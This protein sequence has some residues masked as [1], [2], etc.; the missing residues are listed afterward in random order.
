MKKLADFSKTHTCTDIRTKVDVQEGCVGPLHQDLLRRTMK[1]LIHEVHAV[2]H[3][4][5]DLLRVVLK[6]TQETSL[7]QFL[8]AILFGV[9]TFSLASSPSTSISR[10]GYMDTYCLANTLY[11]EPATQISEVSS[12]S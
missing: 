8:R 6:P 7:P 11:L 12:S 10:V 9:I 2:P 1:S 5:L 4:G 3:H